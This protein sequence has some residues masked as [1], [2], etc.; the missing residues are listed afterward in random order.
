MEPKYGWIGFA[1]VRKAYDNV[2]LD[3]LDRMIRYECQDEFIIQQWEEQYLDMMAL[4]MD[5]NGYLIKRTKGLPQGSELAPVLFNFYT[6]IILRDLKLADDVDYGIFADN[7]VFTANSE[8]SL[9]EAMISTNIVLKTYGLEFELNEAFISWTN[10]TLFD[11]REFT[12]EEDALAKTYKF[13]GIPWNFSNGKVLFNWD[14]VKFKLTKWMI[15]PGYET[16]KM[17]KKFLIPK[18]RY[19]WTYLSKISKSNAK[20]YLLW[21]KKVLRKW[22]QH[23]LIYQNISDDFMIALIFPRKNE[24]L[25][26]IDLLIDDTEI[27]TRNLNENQLKLI[28]RLKELG[29]IVVKQHKKI[30]IYQASNLL[31]NDLNIEDE[32]KRNEI[33]YGKPFKRSK[34]VMD[35]LMKSIYGENR[36]ST[37]IFRDQMNF[38]KKTRRKKIFTIFG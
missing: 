10:G 32:L 1:D 2:D 20:E 12:Q 27:E 16:I 14:D 5:V 35:I 36:I 11:T 38:A 22:L 6:T 34:M 23:Q 24:Y 4:N 29:S 3:H 37:A 7:W 28:K 9:R 31:F 13:L 25:C 21:F 8:K 30:G 33:V 15:K 17:A 26:A 19:Y 18:F